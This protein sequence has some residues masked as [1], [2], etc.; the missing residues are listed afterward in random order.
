MSKYISSVSVTLSPRDSSL[1]LKSV[2]V[3]LDYRSGC[4]LSHAVNFVINSPFVK[5][6]FPKYFVSS[7]NFKYST[8]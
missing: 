3:C 1:G 6:D 4:T 5:A 8:L 2:V 7:L